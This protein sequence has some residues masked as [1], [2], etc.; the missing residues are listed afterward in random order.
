MNE[1]LKTLVYIMAA[2]V[3]V[4]VVAGAMMSLSQ[5]SIAEATMILE[6]AGYTVIMGAPAT[7]NITGA[8]TDGN[9]AEWIT[10]TVVGN[11]PII[12]LGAL[13]NMGTHTLTNVVDPS[14]PQDAA[15]KNYVDGKS[16]NVTG[17]GTNGRMTK[18]SGTSTI[19]DATNT[20]SDV[21]DAVSKKH[22]SGSDTALGSVGTQNPPID[23]DKVL[24]R[25]TVG[26]TLVTSTWTQV[27]AFLKT[28][29]DGV[30]TALSGT[31]NVT[32]LGITT[33]YVPVATSTTGIVNSIVTAN[34]TYMGVAGGVVPTG[35]IIMTAGATVDGVDVSTVGVASHTQGTDT[36][37]GGVGTQNPPIDTDK[38]L[39][40]ATAGDILVTSTWTQVK[41]Y[42][43]TYFDGIYTALGGTGNVTATS[44]ATGYVPLSTSATGIT[45]SIM[46]GNGTLL[47]IPIVTGAELAPNIASAN[48]TAGAGWTVGAGTLTHTANATITTAYPTVAIVPSTSA[49]YLVTSTISSWTAG[50][51]TMTLGGVESSALQGNQSVYLYVSPYTTG[52]VIFTPSA[53]FAG[54]I[55]AVS[56]KLYTGGE[57]YIDG[58]VVYYD[59]RGHPNRLSHV[60]RHLSEMQTDT[61]LDKSRSTLSCTGGVLTYTLYAVYGQGTWNFNGVVYPGAVASA[62]VTL[63]G[64]TDAAP[65]INWVY[66]YLNGNTPTL[67]ASTTEPTVSPQIMVAEFI[68]GNVSGSSYTIYGY[69]RARTEVDSFVKRVIGRF[70]NSG[71]LYVDGS[72]PT[73]NATSLS[74]ASG[75]RWYQGIFEM[76]AANT[77]T[78]G[79]FY[80]INGD[81]TYSY[82]TNIADLHHY[83]NPAMTVVGT[84]ERVNIVWGIVPTTTT[85]SGTLP[86]TVKLFAVLSNLPSSVYTSNTAAEQD[87]YESTNYYP[88]NAQLKEDF[89]PIARTILRPSTPAFQTFGGG[90]YYKDLRGKVT[91][92][93]SA[94]TS[95]P[96]IKYTVQAQSAVQVTTTDS[97]T[98]YW[99]AFPVAPST[100]AA[101]WRIY[102]PKDG[103]I[104][105]AYVYSYAATAGSNENWSMYIRLNDTTDTLI[106]TLGANTN[107]RVWTNAA[108]GID[109]VAGDYIEI[110][111][112]QPA[113]GTNP[114]DVTRTGV[115]YIE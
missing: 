35:N 94:P 31:G 91:S 12:H 26:D 13:L 33:G 68:V 38:L 30:Y 112:I 95:D 9:I 45:N 63:T 86:T 109:V 40:R 8:G 97:Q 72:L 62:S 42:L 50:T 71:S 57:I 111:E 83:G 75:G 5:P 15:T 76:T 101:R 7:G 87:V 99:G 6:E 22:S 37:L 25:A 34:T 65:V 16:S 103:I 19:I 55:S 24:Y 21:A 39:Y 79:G 106:Q 53:S 107:D 44:M 96:T 46:T 81:G 100:T 114:A 60:T 1:E 32:A 17:V 59:S 18:W 41:A 27:K 88:P 92:G 93:G 11:S 3:L 58:G 20:D 77:V 90:S 85:A 74:V 104:R 49:N 110:K 23:T 14:N 56:V 64:G 54:V 105:T 102:I 61:L 69:N 113:W 29:F 78:N 28:Y 82:S 51:V 10:A 67:A 89:I 4:V 48:W 84:N 47:S 36:A 98:M 80:F 43:K 66:F 2:M 52:N 70:E 115:V 73:V 108:L